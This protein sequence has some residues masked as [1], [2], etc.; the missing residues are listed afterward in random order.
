MGDVGSVKR[1][2]VMRLE[3][4]GGDASVVFKFLS[5]WERLGEGWLRARPR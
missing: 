1:G 5:L 3:R 4:S 2:R